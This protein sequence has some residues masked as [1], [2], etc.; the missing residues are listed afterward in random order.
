MTERRSL[1]WTQ[2]EAQRDH[3]KGSE[4]GGEIGGVV[5][6]VLVHS[7]SMRTRHGLPA[8]SL[9]LLALLKHFSY[10]AQFSLVL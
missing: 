6:I 2:K 1:S 4:R 9:L 7:F 5:A 3:M 8:F 10:M